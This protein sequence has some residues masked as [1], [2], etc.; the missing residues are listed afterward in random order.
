MNDEPI[1]QQIKA[2][3]MVEFDVVSGGVGTSANN[4][5]PILRM[6]DQQTRHH[7]KILRANLAIS[8][9]G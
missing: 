1:C 7:S 6:M 4:R 3:R 2:E 9:E 8:G 5:E